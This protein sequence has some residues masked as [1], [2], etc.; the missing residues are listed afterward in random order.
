MCC[1][2]VQNKFTVAY[3]IITYNL[4]TW[5]SDAGHKLHTD[6]QAT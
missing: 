4:M 6:V 3:I 2:C 1:R 5:A